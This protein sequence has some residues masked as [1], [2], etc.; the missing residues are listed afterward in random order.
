MSGLFPNALH[1]ARREY[2][3]RVRGRAFA[4]TTALL[5]VTVAAVTMVPTIL[6][7]VGV[8]DPP[9][10]AVD[11]QAEDLPA[12]PVLQLQLALIGA[13]GSDPD[14]EDA[15]RPRV[16]RAEDPAAAAQ[17]VRD[18]E[19]DALLTITRDDDG[20]LAYEYLGSASPTN[21]TRQVVTAFAQQFTIADRLARA[22]IDQQETAEIFEPPEFT[23]EPVDPDDAADPDDFGGAFI[24]AYAVVILT[25][26]AILTYGNWVAQSVAEEKSNRVMELLITAATPRQLLI[27]KVLGTGAAGLTQYAAIV[28]AAI[29][30]FVANGPVADALGVGGQ[31]PISL[32]DTA[33]RS[34]AGVQRL[35][36]ARLPA[37]RDP[38]RGSRIDGEPHRGRPAG[39]RAADLPRD[40][41]L[42]RSVHGPQR[43]RCGVG[44]RPV[45][46]SLLQPIPDAGQ[47]AAHLGEHGRGAAGIGVPGAGARGRA[48]ARVTDLQRGGAPL[49]PARGPSKRLA[50]HPRFALTMASATDF[51]IV[52][53]RRLELSRGDITAERVDA[54]ANAANERLRGGGGVDGAIHR[55]AGP[56]LLDELRRRYPDGTP[57][58][59]AV[60]TDAH[61]LPARWVLHAVG[62]IW[63]GGG[64]GEPELLAGAYRSSL[65]LADE[66]GAR[67]I[68]F[69]AI[70]M[71]IYGYPPPD[72]ARVAIRT[73]VEHLGGPTQV[74]L[75]RFVLFSEETYDLFADALNEPA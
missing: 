63:R 43:P 60:A 34:A 71:G 28:A 14:A 20:E 12:D 22:G 6:S 40:R 37:V 31:A 66:L 5:A 70:S 24:L 50:R 17:A 45:A 74:E 1:V 44:Q 51:I 38:L 57:T 58:G 39:G 2:L 54:I 72:G 13:S 69:P 33:S 35:L 36:P 49:R 10:I 18:G 3:V 19:L 46:G 56:G 29:I 4:I 30:A 25:F 41:R 21:Q 52:G 27:G 61:D 53:G 7:A 11:V 67:S 32:P 75:A 55:A 9:Q 59:T 68:A 23:A 26:M 16:T 8:A 62:P 65:R 42:F 64:E 47:D 48:L 73:V 15:D